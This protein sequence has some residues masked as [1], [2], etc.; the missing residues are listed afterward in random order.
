ENT[1]RTLLDAGPHGKQISAPSDSIKRLVVCKIDNSQE[2]I[3]GRLMKAI[4]EPQIRAFTGEFG[5]L[6]ASP[7]YVD[8]KAL[9]S[10]DLFESFRRRIGDMARGNQ[11]ADDKQLAPY[12][13]IQN[14]T[15]SL[16]QSRG[17][18]TPEIS[19]PS[20]ATF[21]VLEVLWRRQSATGIS[22]CDECGGLIYGKVRSD[23]AV[24][25]ATCRQRRSRRLRKQ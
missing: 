5:F 20:L 6:S 24:C 12:G 19:A 22:F 3:F 4:T 8:G 14:L 17:T 9:F 21:C 13:W 25:S 15:L 11:V 7:D 1:G 18:T 2:P 23:K 16:N 10:L